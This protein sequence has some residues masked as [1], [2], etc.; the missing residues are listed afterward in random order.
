MSWHILGAG[1]LGALWACRLAA[2]GLAPTLILRDQAKLE[3]YHQAQGLTLNTTRYLINAELPESDA[4]IKR[5]LVTCKAYDAA[6]AVAAVRHRLSQDAELILLQNGIG[7][8]A[9]VQQQAPWA[10]CILGSSTEGAYRPAEFTVMP[11]GAGQNFLGTLQK[12]AP[13]VWLNELAQANIAHQWSEDIDMRLWRKLALNCAINPLTVLHD[14]RNGQLLQHQSVL[15]EI[16]QELTCLLNASGQ[17][18]AAT[19]LHAQVLEVIEATANNYSSMH[20]DVHAKRRTEIAYLL[21]FAVTKARELTLT[22]PALDRLYRD[23]QAHLAE[24]GLPLS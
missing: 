12:S 14:C 22:T 4:P 10:R 8:Q 21:G 19:G 1:S 24:R 18:I 17:T 23:L 5:L 20:Q 6:S 7:S 9:K 15:G 16:T 13:P 2:H 3:R 11:A